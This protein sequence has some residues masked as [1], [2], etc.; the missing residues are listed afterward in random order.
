MQPTPDYPAAV[1]FLERYAAEVGL[2]YEAIE[3]SSGRTIV[4]MT[5]LGS[6]PE[7]PSLVLNSH[8]DVVPV[9]PGTPLQRA[10]SSVT[11]A[12]PPPLTG[13]LELYVVPGGAEHEGRG[14]KGSVGLHETIA[15]AAWVAPPVAVTPSRTIPY[16]PSWP[17]SPGP[18]PA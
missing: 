10:P 12:N 7:L 5:W 16:P 1:A 11:K 2:P 8:T 15:A 17:T 4:L 18:A 13:C 9:F 3:I 6:Q 14:G